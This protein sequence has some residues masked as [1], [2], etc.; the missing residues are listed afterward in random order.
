MLISII[1]K[2][3]AVQATSTPKA[4]SQ[5]GVSVNIS[6][7][8]IQAYTRKLQVKWSV[9]AAEDLKAMHNPSAEKSLIRTLRDHVNPDSGESIDFEKLI[10]ELEHCL[11][12]HRVKKRKLIDIIDDIL[13]HKGHGMIGERAYDILVEAGAIKEEEVIVPVEEA[14]LT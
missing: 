8:S 11:D 4:T 7:Q 3:A 5:Q 1:E 12:S 2:A 10:Y 9:N 14:E 13:E 6:Q